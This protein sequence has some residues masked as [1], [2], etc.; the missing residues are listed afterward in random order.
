MHAA[1]LEALEALISSGADPKVVNADE[2]G[3]LHAAAE[4]GNAAAIPWLLDLGLDLE[5]R[6]GRGHTPLHI[7]CALGRVEAATVL[8]EAGA[9]AA[10]DSPNGDARE[11]ALAE[12]K[13]EIVEMLDR[14]SRGWGPTL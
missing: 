11:I 4:C 7:A 9:D 6:T 8:L 12:G 13:S 3:A 5:A 1:P 14:R 10:A 2:F